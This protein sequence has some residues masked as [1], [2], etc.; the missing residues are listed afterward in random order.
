MNAENAWYELSPYLYALGGLLAY[1][2]TPTSILLKL[3]GILLVLAAL[4]ILR[5][6]WRYRS[7]AYRLIPDPVDTR[8]GPIAHEA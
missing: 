5:L 3:S 6:R 7:A 4:T 8:P 2:H 1:V